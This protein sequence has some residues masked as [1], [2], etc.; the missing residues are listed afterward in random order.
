[1]TWKLKTP[2]VFDEKPTHFLM[3][4]HVSFFFNL[5]VI[6]FLHHVTTLYFGFVELQQVP[7]D[8]EL[9]YVWTILEL[10]HWLYVFLVVCVWC[11]IKNISKINGLVFCDFSKHWRCCEMFGLKWFMNANCEVF[12]HQLDSP[13]ICNDLWNFD[14]RL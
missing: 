9:M 10:T 12:V 7:R 4:I 1:M 3:E 13:C 14:Y 6:V 5:Q 8:V 2:N 11:R